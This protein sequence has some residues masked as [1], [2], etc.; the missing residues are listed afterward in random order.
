MTKKEYCRMMKSISSL[1]L[2]IILLL[3]AIISYVI[4]LSD[5]NMF[6]SQMS[7]NDET[8]NI[9]ALKTLIEHY[10][11]F[12]F[13]FDFWFT[14]DFYFIFIITLMLFIGV[15]LSF[16]IQKH[17]E[18]F[19]GNLY[20]S[21]IGFKKYL[22]SIIISQSLYIFSII[23]IINII[24]LFVA[25]I[26][27]GFG[28]STE[29]CIYNINYIQ[30]FIIILIQNFIV[31]I[32]TILI[33]AC[34]LLSAAFIKNKYILQALPLFAFIILPQLI[35]STL[36]NISTVV[37]NVALPFVVWNEF[38]AI[39]NILN[40]YAVDENLLFSSI[41]YHLIP[42]VTYFFIFIILYFINIKKNERDYL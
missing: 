23:T 3:T 28:Y 16:Q 26:F 39:D 7:L 17:K 12:E 13:V 31:S 10:N 41:V 37:G 8:I 34:S 14:S 1:A 20:V 36:G 29:I 42:I 11:G 25:F 6:I 4:S 38:K 15:F 22:D 32:V 19:Y 24:Q 33:N 30:A 21:R 35:A 9:E 2:I 5:K 27:G 40:N 18:D